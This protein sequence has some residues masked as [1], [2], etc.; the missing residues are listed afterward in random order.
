MDRTTIIVIVSLVVGGLA[1]VFFGIRSTRKTIDK[2]LQEAKNDLYN[3]TKY[4]NSKVMFG[5]SKSCGRHPYLTT[6][7][8]T[9]LFAGLLIG[10]ILSRFR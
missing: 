7:N 6:T 3:D 9:I 4:K 1:I 2:T 8:A 5:G 10:Y